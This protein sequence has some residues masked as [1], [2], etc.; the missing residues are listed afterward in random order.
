MPLP[1][2]RLDR[3]RVDFSGHLTGKEVEQ[4]VS[5]PD[6]R[7]LQAPLLLDWIRGTFSTETYSHEG[8]R[9]NLGFTVSI[10]WFVI[11]HSCAEYQ[12]LGGSQP[13]V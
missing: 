5:D 7:T 11:C 9:L 4:L 12:M 3:H 6:I 8:L 1:A 13:I 10:R 2:K